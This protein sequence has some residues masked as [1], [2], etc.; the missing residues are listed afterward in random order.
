MGNPTLTRFFSFHFVLP[1]VIVFM[2]VLHLVFLHETGSGNPLGVNSD[3]D[4]VEFHPGFVVK[5]VVGL[6]IALFVLLMISLEYPYVFMDVENFI[7][8]NPLVTPVHI[9]PEW[10]FLFAYTILRSIA[11]KIGGVVA[12][13]I[14]VIVLYFFPYML[15][16]RIRSTGFY[17]LSRVGY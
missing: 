6:L 5:D 13:V 15:R 14:S 1:F 7:P 3:V 17:F 11:R 9:Q 2:V 4:R 8:S 16:H 10:Y 12:L